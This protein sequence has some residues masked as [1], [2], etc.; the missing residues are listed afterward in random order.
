M[1]EEHVIPCDKSHLRSTYACD[2]KLH[3]NEMDDR[4]IVLKCD[5]CLRLQIYEK[6]RT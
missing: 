4:F 2:G 5:T 6:V 3:L 1:T